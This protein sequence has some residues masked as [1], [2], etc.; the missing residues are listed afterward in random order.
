MKHKILID[1][2]ATQSLSRWRGLGR[3]SHD[4]ALAISRQYEFS[5]KY[6]IDLALSPYA[7]K[8]V[9][10]SVLSALDVVRFPLLE[11]KNPTFIDQVY[12]FVARQYEAVVF[13]SPFEG[14]ASWEN[15]IALPNQLSQMKNTAIVSVLYDMIPLKFPQRY[16]YDESYKD[17][18]L[19]RCKLLQQSD[20]ILAISQFS[21]NDAVELLDI[22]PD[23]IKVI[24]AAVSPMFY[25]MRPSEVASFSHILLELGITGPFI[26]SVGAADWRKQI[27]VLL[28]AYFDLS[29]EL[30]Q[31]YQLVIVGDLSR[32]EIKNLS[33]KVDP[34]LLDSNRVVFIRR[35]PTFLMNNLYNS[36][37]LFVF[38]SIYEGFGL[39]VLEAMTTGCLA[40][41]SRSSSLTEIVPSYETLFNPG[42]YQELSA[43]MHRSLTDDNW[44][45]RVELDQYRYS[46]NFNWEKVSKLAWSAIEKGIESKTKKQSLMRAKQISVHIFSPLLP[47][48]SGIAKFVESLIAVLKTEFNKISYSR[49]LPPTTTSDFLGTVDNG[50]IADIAFFQ[51]GNN[52]EFHSEMLLQ[53]KHLGGVVE[54][55]DVVIGEMGAH[56]LENNLDIMSDF[57]GVDVSRWL[58]NV[59]TNLKLNKEYKLKTISDALL[60]SIA[61]Y[62]D[63]IIIHSFHAKNLLISSLGSIK[64]PIQVI[65]HGVVL[66]AIPPKVDIQRFRDLNGIDPSTVVIGA[67]GIVHPV[68]GLRDL[69]KAVGLCDT[70]NI[71]VVLVGDGEQDYKDELIFLA[72]S[73]NVKL[74]ITTWVSDEDFESWLDAVDVVCTLRS[75]SKGETSGAAV[76]AMVHA[77]PVVLSKVGSFVE[78]ACSG[79]QHVEVGDIQGLALTLEPLIKSKELRLEMGIACR[80][81]AEEELGFSSLVDDYASFIKSCCKMHKESM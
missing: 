43:L 76:R 61:L 3:F 9:L 34:D 27:N 73:L 70:S 31:Q 18:Y 78:L 35:A 60:R 58:G 71:E 40:L 52:A 62:A 14:L 24:G 33:D 10:D 5:N 53:I 13:T 75:Y 69:I 22:E 45:T 30:I 4:L 79:I 17:K 26:L 42:D 74:K 23:R 66:E 19:K 48:R 64:V 2:Q 51:L 68:K 81:Y 36:A 67:F 63:G 32:Q 25:K 46:N 49:S 11:S 77:K 29:P 59:W 44:R 20:V 47:D 1:L 65:P 56:L 12:S 41:S 16:L 15:Y 55:H 37:S 57:I 8:G 21:K 72:Q 7:E 50:K 54:I 39:P 38:P 28:D 80:S 6:T